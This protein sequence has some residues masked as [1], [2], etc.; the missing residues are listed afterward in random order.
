MAVVMI[1]SGRIPDIRTGC[2]Q[3]LWTRQLLVTRPVL[4]AAGW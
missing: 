4:A 1:G 2:F 3:V